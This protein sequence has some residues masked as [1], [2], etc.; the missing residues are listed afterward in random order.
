MVERTGQADRT[1]RG[2]R[3]AAVCR[4]AR[5]ARRAVAVSRYC[6]KAVTVHPDDSRLH[7]HLE[8]VRRTLI[9][10][11]THFG[12][13]IPS[14]GYYVISINF[15]TV[16]RHKF[17]GTFA[18]HWSKSERR[19]HFLFLSQASLLS[20]RILDLSLVIPTFATT[21]LRH[22]CYSRSTPLYP[23]SFGRMDIYFW[24]H[25]IRFACL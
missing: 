16:V 2:A 12:A 3:S 10:T 9:Y 23:P 22:S 6:T 11:F 4:R 21:K 18:S 8:P 24:F 13:H 17:S 19:P 5:R 20:T 1:A 7:T 14:S 15:I 25:T